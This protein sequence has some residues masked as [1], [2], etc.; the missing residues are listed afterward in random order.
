MI[1]EFGRGDVLGIVEVLQQNPRTTTGFYLNSIFRF[2][3]QVLAVRY[4]QLSKIPEGLLNFVKMQFPQVGFRLV[5][6]L[7]RYYS[8]RVSSSSPLAIPDPMTQRVIFL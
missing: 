5:R 7:G 1:E 2:I 8:G 4:S 6:L 3:F